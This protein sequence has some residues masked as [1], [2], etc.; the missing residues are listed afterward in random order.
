[1]GHINQLVKRALEKGIDLFKVLKA[2]CVNPALHYKLET[3]LL[4]E[5][6][7]ADFIVVDSLNNFQIKQ[8]YINGE[9]VAENGKTKIDSV[10]VKPINNF[11][12]N[13]ISLSDLKLKANSTQVN[14]IEALNG[15][16]I[17][18][19][20]QAD[21]ILENGF[22]ISN[23]DTDILKIVVKNRYKDAPLAIAFIKNFGFKDGA[24]ASSVAHDS[25][26]II[27]V[28]T[29]DENICEAIN[30][31]ITAKGGIVAISSSEKKILELPIG[32]IMSS[33]NGYEV[34][35]KYTELDMLAK[36]MGST[37]TSP[38]MTLS[39]MALL[40]IPSLKL[41]D[42]GLFDGEKFEFIDLKITKKTQ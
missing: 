10:D 42:L 34:S 40:V 5:G 26:N 17:T 23:Q 37:L 38:F 31:I 3:G 29:S 16:L 8:T 4:R 41:S 14:A 18:N 27:A 39:F 6:D 22:L 11:S 7:F 12:C 20:I 25:H 2:A 9:L 33:E 15:Q 1:L 35:Q 21:A 24:I 28:G 19:K 13:P 36:K 30:D 32:G